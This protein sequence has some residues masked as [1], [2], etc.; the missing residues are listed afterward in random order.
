[1]FR[2]AQQANIQFKL[3][4]VSIEKLSYFSFSIEKIEI[5]PK[6]CSIIKK[7]IKIKK[8]KAHAGWPPSLKIRVFDHNDKH[9]EL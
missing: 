8:V 5:I 6:I 1:M 4:Y 9:S 2:H 3:Q 7:F